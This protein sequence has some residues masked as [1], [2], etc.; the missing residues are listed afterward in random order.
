[1]RDK[2]VHYYFGIDDGI[3]LWTVRTSIPAILP[4]LRDM[5]AE[6]DAGQAPGQEP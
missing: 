4:Q 6:M 1:M 3:V 5:L 2:I